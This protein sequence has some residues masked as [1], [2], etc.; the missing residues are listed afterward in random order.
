MS[1]TQRFLAWKAVW[2][3]LRLHVC[4]LLSALM[5]SIAP[6]VISWIYSL[7]IVPNAMVQVSG[8]A[9]DR[10]PSCPIFSKPSSSLPKFEMSWISSRTAVPA[11]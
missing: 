3:W 7:K 11:I 4:P 2:R 9:T 10:G 1:S 6:G 8:P 5:R